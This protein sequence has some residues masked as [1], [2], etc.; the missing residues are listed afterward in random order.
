[1][2]R[3]QTLIL[4]LLGLLLCAV[5]P[6][7]AHSDDDDKVVIDVT[8]PQRSKYPIAIPLGVEGD[9]SI[10][11]TV[12][13][14]ASFDLSVAGWFK[15]LD[16]KSFLANL[17]SEG[18]GID[19]QP[20]K[21]VGAYGVMKYRAKKSGSRVSIDF[22]LYEIEKG[23]RAVLERTYQG[24]AKDVR[25]LTHMWAND[26]VKYYTGEDGFF[27]SKIVFVTKAGRLRK[28]VVGMDFD[29]HGKYGISNNKSINIFP[30]I[31]RDGSRVAYSSYMF[32]NLDL[33]VASA[34][35]GRPMRLSKRTGMNVGGSFSPDG[36]RMVVTLSRDGNPEI[37]VIDSKSGRL[38]RRLTNNRAIDTAPSWS[39]DG[40]EIAFVSDREGGPQIFVMSATGGNQRRVS[41]NGSYNTT[42]TWSPRK[43]ER[44]IAYTTRDGGNFDIVTLNLTTKAMVRIT[45]NEGTNEEPSFAPNGMAVAFASSR[46]GGAGIYIANADGSGN[47][48]KVHSGN[49]TAIDWGPAPKQ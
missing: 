3:F 43:G 27:G 11:K 4:P 16:E 29:G 48:V 17:R 10:A 12:Q 44:T 1:M 26:V 15:V 42:P 37:Y 40:S 35:G 5:A 7:Q 13:E 6:G 8:N 25:K 41:R 46:P 19:V 36:S 31:S 47:A 49:A 22:K 23:D 32:G 9:S 34:S 33:Y 38:L 45:Q 2:L 18:V 20:W 39:P 30:S 24:D 14:V 28:R 21:D